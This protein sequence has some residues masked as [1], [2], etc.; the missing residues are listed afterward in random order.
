MPAI[1]NVVRLAASDIEASLFDRPFDVLNEAELQAFLHSH[2]L[3]ALPEE[4][5]LILADDVVNRRPGSK[6]RC[7]RVYREAKVRPGQAGLEPDL[8]I[9]EDRPQLI[10]PK[11]NRAPSRFRTPYEAIIETKMDAS[12]EDVLQG[13]QGRVIKPSV[14]KADAGK[15]ACPEE[16]RSIINVI[17]T[18]R[19]DDYPEDER[20]III[21]RTLAKAEP[22]QP[23]RHARLLALELY[24]RAVQELYM[25]F[26]EEPY[27][28]LREK[29]FETALFVYMRQALRVARDALHPVRAQYCVDWRDVLGRSRRHDLVVLGDQ[30]E[31]LALEVELKT[32]HSDRHNWFRTRDLQKEFEAIH[33]LCERGHL[34]RG[35]FLLFRY[36]E[37]RWQEDAKA[38]SEQFPRVELDYRC[39][40][41]TQR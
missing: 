37:L 41:L 31:T 9:L 28:Y 20:T 32:S 2:L 24:E 1:E 10:L 38:A 4:P 11:Q 23:S 3:A 13:R 36:G 12:P 14:L 19:P 15:W 5:E 8:V 40:E 25:S 33:I 27:R 22:I 34:E 30:S 39:A 16:A 7:R 26:R 18:A 21:K 29:D 35:V 17:Y 6:Y